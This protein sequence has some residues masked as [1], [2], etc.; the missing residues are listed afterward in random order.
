MNEQHCALV[1][2]P[3]AAFQATFGERMTGLEVAPVT[4]AVLQARAANVLLSR[5]PDLEE[6]SL[7]FDRAY[8][9]EPGN[10]IHYLFWYGVPN[11]YLVLVAQ[12]DGDVLR[13][14]HRLDLNK[15]Y[16]LAS[17][18]DPVWHR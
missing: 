3:E 6:V 5:P 15:K 16:G 10:C 7:R 13:G 9:A 17:P 2:L 18:P 1:E 4:A 14:Y 11:V 12:A 8:R